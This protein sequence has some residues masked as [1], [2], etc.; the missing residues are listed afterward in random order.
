MIGKTVTDAIGH[1]VAMARIEAIHGGE[2]QL[3]VL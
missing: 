2:L 3:E 1:E